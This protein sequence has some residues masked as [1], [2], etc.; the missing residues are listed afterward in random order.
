METKTLEEL[1]KLVNGKV[2]GNPKVQIK[3]AATLSRASSGDISFLA[4]SKYAKQLRTTKA[5]AVIV[6]QDT[7]IIKDSKVPLLICEDPYYSF[8]QIMVLIH[9][10]RTHKRIGVSKLAAIADSAKIGVDCHIHNFVDIEDNATIGDRCVVYPGVFIGEDVEIGPD[11]IIYPNVSIYGHCKIGKGVI[12]NSNSVIGEDGFGFASY[13]GEHHKIPQIG[14]VVLE[15]SVEIGAG[16]TI[17]RGTLGDTIIEKGCKLGDLVAVGH[18]TRI[19]AHTLLVAQVCISGSANIGRNC[20]IGGQVGITGHISIGNEVMI[21][22]QSE[23]INNVGDKRI[24]LGSPA[25][26]ASTA[27]KAYSLIKNLPEMKKSL[28]EME[29]K[30]YNLNKNDNAE[31]GSDNNE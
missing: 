31:S 1:A 16:C 8:M 27:R 20:I 2:F 5:S 21:G 24:V 19:G 4:N 23:V 25:I 10:H 3:S 9:G 26:D 13:G 12:I 18:G 14:S 11:C 6:G 28:H 7:D 15:D 29:R 30:L 17:E 22:A